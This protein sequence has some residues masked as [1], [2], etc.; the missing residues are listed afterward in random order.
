MKWIEFTVREMTE[1]E[2]EAYPECELIYDCRLP[3]DGEEVLISNG[4]QVWSDVFYNDGS[5]GCWLETTD[6]EEGMAWMPL[7]KPH[8]RGKKY[9]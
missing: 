1:E 7:P 6:L 3:E 9:D 2:K 5:D 4:F 8:K